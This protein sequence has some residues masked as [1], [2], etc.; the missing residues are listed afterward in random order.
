M[1]DDRI[2]TV[3]VLHSLCRRPDFNV[4]LNRGRVSRDSQDCTDLGCIE[5]HLHSHLERQMLV[6]VV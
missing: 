3:E 6:G 2:L 5:A 4:I 1:D